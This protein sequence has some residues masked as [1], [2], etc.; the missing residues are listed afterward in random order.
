MRKKEWKT[1]EKRGMKN[2]RMQIVVNLR[3]LVLSRMVIAKSSAACTP[4]HV[5][6]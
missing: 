3:S 5:M 2:M 4:A 6:I 1:K